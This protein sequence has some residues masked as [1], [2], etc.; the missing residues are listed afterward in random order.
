MAALGIVL[1]FGCG[2]TQAATTGSV[3]MQQASLLSPAAPQLPARGPVFSG[4]L[5]VEKTATQQQ[6]AA[7]VSLELMASRP[8]E[9]GSKV[10]F[11]ITAKR[12]G[13]LLLVDIDAAG[14]MTQIFPNPELLTRFDDVDI[15]VIKPGETLILPPAAAAAR[16]F[17]YV[18]APPAG[19]AAVIA[20]LSEKRVQLLDLPDLPQRLDTEADVVNYLAKWTNELRIPD[21]TTGKLGTNNW[22]FDVRSYEIK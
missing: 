19:A 2:H 22:W 1:A 14:K 13:Y 16:G 6:A 17:Q 11:R 20:I 21:N 15:N 7:I 5:V 4:I 8:I 3:T 18:I 12:A 10:S 9:V